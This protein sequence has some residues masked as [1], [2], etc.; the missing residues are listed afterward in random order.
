M[1]VRGWLD[2]TAQQRAD[3]RLTEP[4][5]PA[6]RADAADPARGSPTR[7]GLWINP[8]KGGDLAGSE[9]SLAAGLHVLPF[10]SFEAGTCPKCVG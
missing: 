4:A 9:Q 6:G 10:L 8:E 1:A 3:L 7:Y 5:V 2:V